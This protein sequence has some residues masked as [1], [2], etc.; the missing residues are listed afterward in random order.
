LLSQLAAEIIA[1]ADAMDG[2][3]PDEI[4]VFLREFAPTP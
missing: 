1:D 4:E 3:I 2:P